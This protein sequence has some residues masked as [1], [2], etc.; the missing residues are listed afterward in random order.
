MQKLK[1]SNVVW[2]K[3]YIILFIYIINEYNSI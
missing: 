1:L 3:F 2:Q